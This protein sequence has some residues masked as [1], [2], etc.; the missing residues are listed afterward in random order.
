MAGGGKDYFFAIG[1]K[2]GA[3]MG[4]M[5]RAH[6]L[7]VAAVDIHGPDFIALVAFAV[8]LKD[9]FFAVPA[10]ISLAIVPVKGQLSEIFHESI[11]GFSD[12]FHGLFF[13]ATSQKAGC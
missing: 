9:K 4:T 6:H 11:I 1:E 7:L 8:G 10:E 13:A 2:K 5:V 12:I 3:G